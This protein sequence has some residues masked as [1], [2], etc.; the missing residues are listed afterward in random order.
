MTK[1]VC[2]VQSVVTIVPHQL[3]PVRQHH[4]LMH[5]CQKSSWRVYL[6]HACTRAR[7]HTHAS[8]HKHAHDRVRA[9]ISHTHVHIY[10]CIYIY[11]RRR[12]HINTHAVVEQRG[13]EG[14]RVR[15]QA[16]HSI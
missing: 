2:E 3:R 9:I 6:Q 5:A 12:V 7:T 8:A 10:I 11:E 14:E 16:M 13:Q 1:A 15:R 4:R